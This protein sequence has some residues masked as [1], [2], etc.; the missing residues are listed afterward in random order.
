MIIEP[1]F[2]PLSISLRLLSAAQPVILRAAVI[3]CASA[4]GSRGMHSLFVL[5]GNAASRPTNWQT[6]YFVQ[7]EVMVAVLHF[8]VTYYCSASL[9]QYAG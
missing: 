7:F 2:I 8:V 1:D 9:M 4:G 6:R 5:L 3:V